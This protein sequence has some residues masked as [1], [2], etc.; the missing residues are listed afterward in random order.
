M[1]NHNEERALLAN[2][3]EQKKI[4]QGRV[5]HADADFLAYQSA[6][7][8]ETEDYQEVCLDLDNR[9]E[10]LRKLACAE[11]IV[12]HLTMGDKGGRGEIARL[13][14]YQGNRKKNECL[15]HR[16]D[17]LRTRMAQMWQKGISPFPQYDQEADDSLCQAMHTAVG[18]QD[19]MWSKDKDLKM[20]GG[21]HLQDNGDL[22]MYPW[23][24]G[25]AWL[26]KSQATAK[27]DGMGR[28]FFWHQLLQGDSAD[29]ITG[30][31]GIGAVKAV[32]MLKEA[33]TDLEAFKI[34]SKAY[35]H[36]YGASKFTLQCW[37][38]KQEIKEPLDMMVEQARLLWMRRY[39]GDDVLFMLEIL[40]ARALKS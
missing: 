20:V 39:R 19:V 12:L 6:S 36:H 17:L 13:K 11:I 28:A 23:G 16:V 29:N 40:R 2:M 14:K 18:G 26:D 7:K 35:L 4:V 8:W 32:S 30:V 33:N 9:I 24:Y 38:G 3:T 37:D 21:Y 15:R 5:L 25:E 10:D 27:I 1:N 31:P 22:V 34:V